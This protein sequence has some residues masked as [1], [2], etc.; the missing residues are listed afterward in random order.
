VLDLLGAATTAG[1]TVPRALGS[2]GS[3]IGGGRG[4]AL[5]AVAAA[6]LWGAP[7]DEAWTGA[8]G[9]LGP[10]AEALRP[11]WE[12]GAAGAAALRAAAQQVRRD[13]GAAAQEAAA[14]LA[15]RLV[16]PLGLCHL[17]AFVLVGIVPVVLALVEGTLA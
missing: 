6:L 15:V 4:D 17:P 11:S 9:A 3:A 2:V 14:R 5:A 16:L 7:W 1:A 10:V 8:P 12:Q 13:S